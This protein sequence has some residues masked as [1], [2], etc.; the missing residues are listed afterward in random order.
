[1]FNPNL[2]AKLSELVQNVLLNRIELVKRQKNKKK[3]NI[4][5]GKELGPRGAF[6]A[7]L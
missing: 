3:W 7:L 6:S 5:G 4:F 1:M 2:R